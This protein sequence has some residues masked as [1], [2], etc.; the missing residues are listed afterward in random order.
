MK[1]PTSFWMN[2]L[3]LAVLLL[4][5]TASWMTSVAPFL[6]AMGCQLLLPSLAIPGLP[7]LPKQLTPDEEETYLAEVSHI[8]VQL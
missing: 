3:A 4:C 6:L 8:V 1:E 2:R 5:M 7:L